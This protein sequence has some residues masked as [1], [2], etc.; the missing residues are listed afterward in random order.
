[1]GGLA[2]STAYAIGGL[3]LAPN[4]IGGNGADP[5]FIRLMERLFSGFQY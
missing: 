5:E 4:Y 2:V 1:L 3:A